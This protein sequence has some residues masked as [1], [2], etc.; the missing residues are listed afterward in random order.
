L[1]T[2]VSPFF[3]QA[4]NSLVG[5]NTIRWEF[6]LAGM[7]FAAASAVSTAV[8]ARQKTAKQA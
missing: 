5:K 6:M 3:F 8:F 7:V 1:G 4:V 2:F